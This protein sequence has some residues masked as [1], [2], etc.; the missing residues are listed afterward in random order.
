MQLLANQ[1]KVEADE[2][3]EAAVAMAAAAKGAKK[4]EME[5]QKARP[6]RRLAPPLGPHNLLAPSRYGLRQHRYS[7]PKES[8]VAL[9]LTGGARGG[10]RGRGDG[11]RGAENPRR[12]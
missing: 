12:G 3:M 6:L 4:E 11:A 5:A 8:T 2:N 9:S 10:A 1:T 7:P